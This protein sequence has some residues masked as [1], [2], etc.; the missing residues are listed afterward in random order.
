MKTPATGQSVAEAW[1]AVLV[2]IAATAAWWAVLLV[3]EP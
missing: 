2:A 3:V 1:L